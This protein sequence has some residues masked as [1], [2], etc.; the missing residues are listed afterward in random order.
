MNATLVFTPEQL[1]IIDQALQQMPYF[2]VAPLINDIN[3][4]LSEAT[5]AMKTAN[6]LSTPQKR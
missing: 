6:N 5:E 1:S 2:K 3:R 4:Q